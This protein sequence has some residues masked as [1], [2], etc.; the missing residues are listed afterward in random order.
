MT[1]PTSGLLAGF[2]KPAAAKKQAAQFLAASKLNMPMPRAMAAA[3]ADLQM[4]LQAK[5]QYKHAAATSPTTGDSRADLCRQLDQLTVAAEYAAF[6]SS[7]T[8]APQPR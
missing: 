7:H 6:K 4:C 5:R 1:R 8:F 3:D 2:N